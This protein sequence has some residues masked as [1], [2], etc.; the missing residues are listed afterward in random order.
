[1]NIL[2]AK[3]EIINT[4]RAY[5]TKD[6]FGNPVIVKQRQRPIFLL[7]VPGVGKT[8]IVQQ[9]ADEL[10]LPLVSYSMTHHTR[11]SALGL[12][13]IKE[14]EFDGKTYR[15]TEY[16]MSEIIASIYHKMEKTGEKEGILFLDEINCVSE[17]LAPAMLQFL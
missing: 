12:P 16:T 3:T 4:I 2:Q 7:G 15:M 5:R 17:T 6:E 14:E 11:Q 1:M 9:V 10:Q 13:Y 8:D